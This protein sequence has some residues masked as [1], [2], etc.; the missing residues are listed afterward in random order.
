MITNHPYAISYLFTA[1]K[2]APEL[3]ENLLQGL[4]SEE[5]DYRHDPRRFTIREIMAHLADWDE[6]FLE[7]LKRVRDEDNPTIEGL[8]EGELAQLH[9]YAISDPHQQLTLFRQRRARLVGYLRELETRDWSR[10]CL[11]PEIG[12]TNMEEMALIIPL[13]DTYHLLQVTEWLTAARKA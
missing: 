6:I 13:H 3:F 9:N 5:A 10:G 11:R 7:R 2:A 4:T 8:D 1:L 12:S